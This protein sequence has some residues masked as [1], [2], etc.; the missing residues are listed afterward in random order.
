M[1]IQF[2]DLS[3]ESLIHLWERLRKWV[4]EE[5]SSVQM[6]LRLSEASALYQQGKTGL[7]KQPD[8][9]LAINWREENKPNLWWAQKYNPAFERAM[10]YLRTSEKE[11]IESE[12]RKIRHNRWRLNRIK[13]I[14]SILGGI[15]IVAALTTIAA[16]VSKFSSDNR[17]KIAET[18]KEEI[19]DRK[20]AAD[21][22]AS[23]VLKKSVLSD[24]S[25]MAAQRREQ[26][27]KMLRLNAENQ[28]LT[29]QQEI[30]ESRKTI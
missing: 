13:I 29:V 11:F 6:Y 23:V 12:E 27:E 20:D 15:A 25:A 21:Q 19:A 4:D 30:D 3:H 5:S 1:T 14:S 18:Q 16:F 10:V 24:S 28:I 9:Q 22:Y 2:I 17:R 26:M 8:L 7:L